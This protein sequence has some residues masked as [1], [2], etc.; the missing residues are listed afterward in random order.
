MGPFKIIILPLIKL[1]GEKNQPQVIL[2][3][4]YDVRSFSKTKVVLIAS[5]GNYIHTQR[6]TSD[7]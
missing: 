5:K 2:N 1:G 4:P 3:N 6:T 7:T